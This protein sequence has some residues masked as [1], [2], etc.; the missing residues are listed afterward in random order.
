MEKMR[1]VIFG[2]LIFV[3]GIIGGM[4]SGNLWTNNAS[5]NVPKDQL[6]AHSFILVDN[7]GKMR[8]ALGF[9][10]DG[11]PVLLF[12]DTEG[13]NRGYFG[14]IKQGSMINL[15]DAGGHSRV[16][17]RHGDET[18]ST[19]GILGETGMPNAMLRVP[20]TQEPY[21]GFFD[22]RGHG[23]IGL[24][25]SGGTPGL[26]FVG[27]DGHPQLMM[28][29]RD[30]QGALLTLHDKGKRPAVALG[31]REGR[32]FIYAYDQERNGVFAGAQPRRAPMLAVMRGG[33]AAWS[34][35]PGGQAP[36]PKEFEPSL[37]LDALTQG[38]SR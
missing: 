3:G 13:N 15:K 27:A 6:L 2:C 14:L 25:I 30:G 21:F 16:V 28:Q 34:A 5:A 38:L 22:N 31:A 24:G 35:I 1:V 8:A 7:N 20:K 9:S 11:Y 19:I 29:A 32:S 33:Q 37:D 12:K 17:M 4:I 26:A 36:E 23:R 18:G 10:D